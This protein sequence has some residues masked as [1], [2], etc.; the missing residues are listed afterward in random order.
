M[1][2]K[3]YFWIIITVLA[4]GTITIRSGF[5]FLSAKVKI[6]DRV[7]EIFT[8]IPAA[9]LPAML[10]PM[11]FF[12]QGSSDLLMHKE[13][14]FVT[15]AAIFVSYYSKSMIGTVTFGLAALFLVKF[16]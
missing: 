3:D 11:V 7:R 6:S 4:I 12:H 13:R 14:L 5:I 15:I 10:A 1:I 9:I 2:D 16:L 8:F